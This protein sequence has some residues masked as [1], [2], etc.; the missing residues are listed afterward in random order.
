[1][2]LIG[3]IDVRAEILVT[4]LIGEVEQHGEGL[5]AEIG[6]RLEPKAVRVLRVLDAEVGAIELGAERLG[7]QVGD[8]LVLKGLG[9]RLTGGEGRPIVGI[10]IFAR[11]VVQL[12]L[13]GHTVQ[14]RRREGEG[15]DVLDDVGGEASPQ[16]PV[17]IRPIRV[18]AICDALRKGPDDIFRRTLRHRS[19]RVLYRHAF[20]HGIGQ[21]PQT[22]AKMLAD[23]APR[24]THP[25]VSNSTPV[26]LRANA[27]GAPV[28]PSP[29]K[30]LA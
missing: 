16:Y 24:Q 8:A 11:V 13:A 6:V 17:G 30:A 27:K 28:T 18:I 15:E 2:V 7:D 14:R 25:T 29:R 1:M 22:D 21:L 23:P 19:V 26:P 3:V 10:E 20:P 5:H 9:H 4:F 12:P